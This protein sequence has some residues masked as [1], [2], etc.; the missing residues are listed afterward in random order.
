M[1]RGLASLLWKFLLPASQTGWENI[2]GMCAKPDWRRDL[3]SRPLLASAPNKTHLANIL[4]EIEKSKS[5]NLIIFRAVN[6]SFEANSNNLHHHRDASGS[7]MLW[8]L[9]WGVRF[10]IYENRIEHQ[11]NSILIHHLH[12]YE[13]FLGDSCSHSR[14]EANIM[15]KFSSCQQLWLNVKDNLRMFVANWISEDPLELWFQ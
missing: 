10:T 7:A 13:R 2:F 4:R 12:C 14:G 5:S 1:Q 11:T 8:C 15:F 9:I 6:Q 3:W